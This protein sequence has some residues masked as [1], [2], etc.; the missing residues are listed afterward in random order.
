MTG[1]ISDSLQAIGVK[2]VGDNYTYWAYVMK[3][4]LLGKN[5][6]T[7]VIGESSMPSD[8]KLENSNALLSTWQVTN[9]K[10]VTWINNSVDQSIGIHFG[11]FT[12]AK[13]IWDHL[14]H[15]YVESN[16]AKQYQLERKIR[17]TSQGDKSIQ[18]FYSV[19]TGLWDQLAF[20]KLKALSTHTEYCTYCEE[21]RSVQFLMALRA[22]FEGLCGTILHC[23]PLPTIDSVVN[24]LLVEEIR[25]KGI[26]GKDLLPLPSQTVLVIP[27]SNQSRSSVHTPLD[28]CSFCHQ[29]SHWKAQCLRLTGRP[30]SGSSLSW[31]KGNDHS[32]MS[33]MPW[34]KGW[35]SIL[36]P[37]FPP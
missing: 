27:S 7:Y 36:Q 34:K 5:V 4:F 29:K 15:L 9:A 31:K 3:N 30:H 17:A 35:N 8:V 14:S 33:P 24:E 25:F 11:K 12:T 20:T 37:P 22:D 21:Q 16:F 28:E 13:E 19:T 2:S 18:E 32:S 6:W 26:L 23:S 1:G 10:I